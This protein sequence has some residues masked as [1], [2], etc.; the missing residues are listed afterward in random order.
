[1]DIVDYVNL[2]NGCSKRNINLNA[3]ENIGYDAFNAIC[4]AK[5]REQIIDKIDPKYLDEL[6]DILI[7]KEINIRLLYCL[8]LIIAILSMFI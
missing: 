6:R 8:V 7:Q 5:N 1:M 3:I 2:E 4:K